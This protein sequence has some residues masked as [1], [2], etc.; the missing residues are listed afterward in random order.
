MTYRSVGD[1]F[2]SAF[3]PAVIPSPFD[4]LW[5]G[6]G[7]AELQRIGVE[8]VK[9]LISAKG[10]YV[11]T[12]RFSSD[13]PSDAQFVGR[14]Q[15]IAAIWD[16]NTAVSFA[17]FLVT[18]LVYEQKLLT[19]GQAPVTTLGD[20]VQQQIGTR[21][22][23]GGDPAGC[24]QEF[25]QSFAAW[26][27][28]PPVTK[29]PTA[30]CKRELLLS[31]DSCT[32]YGACV[33]NVDPTTRVASVVYVPAPPPG[34]V[35]TPGSDAATPSGGAAPTHAE[36]E[37]RVAVDP[38]AAID[39]QAL[40]EFGAYLSA[41]AQARGLLAMGLGLPAAATDAEV[42]NGL[43]SHGIA[44]PMAIDWFV[45][46]DADIAC[47]RQRMNIALGN[48]EQSL[49]DER[50]KFWTAAFALGAVGYAAYVMRRRH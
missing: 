48:S 33:R 18:S 20:H 25:Q 50:V 45:G 28:L 2:M 31:K 27:T 24:M 12:I 15:S 7:L 14:N 17:S 1:D 30:W 19:K 26:R 9:A 4:Y 3:A 39:Q 35:V 32:L 21:L 36:I 43:A 47:F 8:T 42:W 41:L 37:A 16:L 49:K 38:T 46:C 10:D 40:A 44:P 11:H 22:F 23:N 6:P 5:G 29:T 13:T 34:T